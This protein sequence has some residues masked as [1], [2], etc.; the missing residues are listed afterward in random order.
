MIAGVCSAGM[1]ENLTQA[2]GAYSDDAS[3]RGVLMTWSEVQGQQHL[4]RA[5]LFG[6]QYPSLSSTI[7]I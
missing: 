4:V 6:L 5:D 7:V 3:A 1:S 2:F